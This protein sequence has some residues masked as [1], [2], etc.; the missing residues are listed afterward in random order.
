MVVLVCNHCLEQDAV[1]L[2][3]RFTELDVFTFGIGEIPH[4]CTLPFCNQWE[5]NL[6][7]GPNKEGVAPTAHA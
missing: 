7:L 5:S 2:S 3:F 4:S 6:Y 1:G